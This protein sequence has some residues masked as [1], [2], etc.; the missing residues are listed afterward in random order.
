MRPLNYRHLHYF[1]ATA[2]EG[3]VT[4]AAELLHVSQPAVSAQIKKLERSLG[5]ELFDRSGRTMELT[6]EGRIVMDYADEI[7][8]LGRELQETVHGRLEGRQLF[9]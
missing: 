7:F 2:R 4:A 9:A 3:S 6:S 1:W 8:R 5:H